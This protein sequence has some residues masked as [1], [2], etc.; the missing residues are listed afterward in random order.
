MKEL[1]HTLGAVVFSFIFLLFFIP[2]A[3]AWNRQICFETVVNMTED[4]TLSSNDSVFYRDQNGNIFSS[5]ENPIL[6]LPGCEELC[7]V[8]F[9]WYPDAGPRLNTWLIPVVL[10]VANMEVSPLDKRRYLMVFHL[11]GDPIDSIWSMLSKLEA[12]SRC[13]GLARL[14]VDRGFAQKYDTYAP[15]IFATLLAGVEELLGPEHNPLDAFNSL[16][17]RAKLSLE[18]KKVFKDLVHRTGFE[19]ADS[20]TDEILRT[21]FAVV[22]YMYQLI[23]AFVT[24]VGGGNTS[25]PGGRIGTAMFITWL[26]PVILLSNLIGGFTSRTVCFRIME[27]FVQK[28]RSHPL[29]LSTV[30]HSPL[31]KTLSRPS[32]FFNSQS[33][34]GSVYTYVQPKK[35]VYNARS[36]DRSRLF[37]LIL[38]ILPIIIASIFGSAI[39]WNTPP[40]GLSCRNI[41]LIVMTTLWFL[42]TFLTWCISTIKFFGPKARWYII[43]AKDFVIGFPIILTIFLSSSGI[44][45]SCRCWSAVYSLGAMAHVPLNTNAFFNYDDTHLY[46]ILV[47]ICLALEL[48]LFCYIVFVGRRGIRIIRWS[49]QE[50]RSLHEQLH[51]VLS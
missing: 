20:R 28:V 10:L 38:S 19:L 51:S 13:D 36:N 1:K 16:L 48:A 29:L 33:W 40:E 5:P 21:I 37:L 15:K 22:L 8:P 45:N 23:A 31:T 9:N 34:S 11:L 41:M 4:G 6:T 35:I 7:G 26:V 50:K 25:P 2:L 43:L 32:E 17:P 44:F 39:I 14:D 30:D 47:S 18:G 24:T 49:E 27:G 42:S 12:W 3:S 46:P